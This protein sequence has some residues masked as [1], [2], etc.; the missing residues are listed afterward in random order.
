MFNARTN[1]SQLAARFRR[2]A[3]KL[4]GALKAGLRTAAAQIDKYQVDNLK[5]HNAAESGDYPVPSRTGPSH[6]ARNSPRAASRSM[7]GPCSLW[8]NL[9]GW[10]FSPWM[11][12]WRLTH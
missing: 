6:A 11:P 12:R 4:G 1:A 10:V 9:P 5:G 3:E 8:S 7:H 2:R